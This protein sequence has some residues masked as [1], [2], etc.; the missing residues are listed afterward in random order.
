MIALEIHLSI[1][2]T[3]LQLKTRIM[4]Y[5]TLSKQIFWHS[6]RQ[7][8]TATAI[9][10]LLSCPRQSTTLWLKALDFALL[11]IFWCKII[12]NNYFIVK[13]IEIY[14]LTFTWI[15]RQKRM[16]KS[17]FVPWKWSLLFFE[18]WKSNFFCLTW[19]EITEITFSTS[20][21]KF[22]IFPFVHF[23]D[24][25]LAQGCRLSPTAA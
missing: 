6:D 11:N 12:C 9:R 13:F 18:E 16:K 2:M 4:H 23:D 24:R 1:T 10:H 5:I 25:R 17:T 15:N 8:E 19:I 20:C 3:Y 7:H 22:K 21:K 14:F